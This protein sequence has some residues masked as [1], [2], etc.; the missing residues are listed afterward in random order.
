MP[1]ALVPPGQNSTL[2]VTRGDSD[3]FF[4]QVHGR[5]V[6]ITPGAKGKFVK[7][8]LDGCDHIRVA[9]TDLVNVVAVKVH[10]TP[11]LQIFNVDTVAGA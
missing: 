5:A 2:F 7:L 9:K 4:C 3:Q 10:I 8:C 6:S 11:S 1:I